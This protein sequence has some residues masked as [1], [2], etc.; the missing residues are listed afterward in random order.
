MTVK[1]LDKDGVQRYKGGV[2]LKSSQAYTKAFG[3]ACQK[4]AALHSNDLRTWAHERQQKALL[5]N[6]SRD[7]LLALRHSPKDLW[8]DAELS[9]VFDE[10]I[11][12]R[13]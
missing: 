13:P 9:A 7:D 12:G 1:Y 10:L 6:I 11:R 3:E 2:H 4:V 8:K 5:E